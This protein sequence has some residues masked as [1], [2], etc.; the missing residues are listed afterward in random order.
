MSMS[1]AEMM[2]GAALVLSVVSLTVVGTGA[3][4]A[5]PISSSKVF[6]SKADCLRATGTLRGC[7]YLATGSVKTANIAP[8]AVTGA[9]IAARSVGSTD[10]APNAVTTINMA[11]QSVTST[12]IQNFTITSD[13]IKKLPDPPSVVADAKGLSLPANSGVGEL[14][15]GRSNSAPPLVPAANFSNIFPTNPFQNTT[16]I[17]WTPCATDPETPGDP[18]RLP[19][20][21][22]P[23]DGRYTIQVM[24]ETFGDTSGQRN[25]GVLITGVDGPQK[26]DSFSP[27]NGY[28]PFNSGL[29]DATSLGQTPGGSGTIQATS[30]TMDLKAGQAII[31]AAV[32]QHTTLDMTANIH[33]SVTK[34]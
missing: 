25:I 31:V 32:W 30:K 11:P 5:T 12:Q 26:K 22:V 9:K 19:C 20:V 21:R 17:V 33:L 23:E 8:N 13:D 14:V 3:N 29:V 28:A 10:I 2:A 24:M 16:G 34:N 27:A 15:V 6:S 4:A 1:R 18:A 7:L